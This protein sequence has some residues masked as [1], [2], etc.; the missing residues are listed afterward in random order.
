MLV[1]TRNTSESIIINNDIKVTVLG[2]QGKQVRLGIEA[3]RDVAVDREEIRDL[4]NA[5]IAAGNY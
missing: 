3:P 1:L 4:K 2:V 5:E